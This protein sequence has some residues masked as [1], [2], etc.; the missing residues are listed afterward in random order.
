MLNKT[1]LI[2]LICLSGL[3]FITTKQVKSKELYHDELK[4][5][6]EELRYNLIENKNLRNTEKLMILNNV[7]D[8]IKQEEI[9]ITSNKTIPERMAEIISEVARQE[10]FED[11]DL[12]IRIAKAESGLNPD[13][14]GKVDKS[15]RGLFQISSYYNKNV[16]DDCA[17]DPWC[18]TKWTINEIKNKNLWKWNASKHNWN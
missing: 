1:L 11:K 8:V 9:K 7:N 10:N 17:F 3:L 18:S 6:L 16:S 14:I 13:A 4:V 12:L 5:K 2:I 15:D